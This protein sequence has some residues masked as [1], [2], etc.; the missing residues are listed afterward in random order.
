MDIMSN[1]TNLSNATYDILKVTGQD[2]DFLYDII[3]AY[4]RDAEIANN[5]ELADTW[6]K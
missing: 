5:Q 1:S 2:A 6:K 4:I 3:E